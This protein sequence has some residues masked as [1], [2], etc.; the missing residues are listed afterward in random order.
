MNYMYNASMSLGE[1]SDLNVRMIL[2]G[3]NFTFFN[4]SMGMYR[5]FTV[6]YG[7]TDG[8]LSCTRLNN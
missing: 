4:I 6:K 7:I 1:D 8:V 2:A 5:R 3:A